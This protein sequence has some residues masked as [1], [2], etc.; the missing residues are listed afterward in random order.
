[1]NQRFEKW[2]ISRNHEQP[3]KTI[4]Y[5]KLD[6]QHELK[7]KVRVAPSRTQSHHITKTQSVGKINKVKTWVKE[8]TE[9][10]EVVQERTQEQLASTTQAKPQRAVRT[11]RY[12]KQVAKG[13]YKLAQKN[14]RLAKSSKDL[15]LLQAS[16]ERLQAARI[17]YVVAK[18]V[19]KGTI[20]RTGG[21]KLTKLGRSSYQSGRKGAESVFSEDE[22]LEDIAAS[23]QQMR[24]IHASV[25]QGKKMARYSQKVVVDAGKNAYGVANRTYNLARGQGFTRTPVAN[26]WETRL[27]QATERMKRRLTRGQMKKAKKASQSSVTALKK[28][29]KT[30]TNLVTNPLRVKTYF[31]G[32]GLILV[33]SLFSAGASTPVSQDEFTMT[34]A[35][36][37]VSKK[38]REESN[39]E[40][41]YWTNIDDIFYFMGF[42][43]GV[44]TL[45]D[46]VEGEGLI[47]F[48]A[49]GEQTLNKIWSELNGDIDNLR[50]M[51]DIYT[52]VDEFKLKD[53]ELAE[54]T[55]LQEQLSEVGRYFTSSE[56][57]DPFTEAGE[58]PITIGKRFGYITTQELYEGSSLL[59]KPG[60]AVYATMSG[61]LS[62]NE[63]EV[64]IKSDDAEF[65]Y[66]K[67]EGIRVKEGE[68]IVAGEPIGV[69][70][71]D[72]FLEIYYK[73]LNRDENKWMFVNPSFYFL[74]VTYSQ[75][76]SVMKGLTI[77][78]DLSSKVRFIYDFMKKRFPKAT[79]NGIAAMLGNF[80][81]ESNIT[82]KRAEGDHL[83][84]P[85]GA[86]DSSWDDSAWL[87]LGG[88]DI[89][90]KHPN[91][92]HRG[93]GLGQWTDTQDGSIRHTLLRNYASSKN[94]KWYDLELQLDFMINGDAP[95]YVNVLKEILT[96]DKSL[97]TLTEQ[98][99]VL[100]EGNLGDK[101]AA[102]Q[103]M[104][105]QILATM[106]NTS[107]TVMG[108][109]GHPFNVPYTVL[110]PYGY[111]PW[112]MGAGYY[113][114]AASGGKHTGVDV[115]AVGYESKDIPIFSVTDGVVKSSYYS[116]LGGHAIVIQVSGT[117]DYIYYGHNK[118]SSPLKVGDSVKKGQQIGVLGNSGM[119]TI[120]H[121]HLEY[122][123]S[124]NFGTGRD[125]KDPS[126]LF[127][128]VV[129][130]LRQNQVITP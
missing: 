15:Q 122:A 61:V 46:K 53:E 39:D 85:I 24:Q 60:Q 106:K 41:D 5:L 54:Y 35:W 63:S 16:K 76:T 128:G 78:S 75:S 29:V 37:H 81:I 99:L 102:R 8:R 19:H 92:I 97:D 59:A 111:T 9:Y 20:K 66:K 112:S 107:T 93:L 84:P 95:Y 27:K 18:K 77:E 62:I 80:A 96:S 123:T 116:D 57:N 70:P 17:D 109:S 79:D 129:G 22:T 13:E 71:S 130:T 28:V 103:E 32:F 91:I 83:S 38:D 42:K 55:E 119:T 36:K 73:K 64:I 88:M 23:R 87:E 113:L 100:W 43:Y 26:R 3:V 11:S 126:F 108:G 127:P 74:N 10:Q 33:I 82:A 40:V 44:W 94:K 90:G 2:T 49:T 117:Q 48:S 105:K 65:T 115:Q 104:A 125:D 114:Y 120:Y 56:L 72:G 4:R 69:A 30:V 98:F 67:L 45:K 101:L 6:T 68:E 89:Y 110:Q 25:D 21:G 118:Y 7:P 12:Q 34:E 86:T 50:N 31:I 52:S 121:I 47:N 14:Y 58:G 51:K 124:Q 1:M